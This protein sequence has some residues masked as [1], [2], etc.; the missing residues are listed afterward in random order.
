MFGD[1]DCVNTLA[2]Q[3]EQLLILFE[4]IDMKTKTETETS[5]IVMTEPK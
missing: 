5:W 1:P 4:N 2:R 3:H